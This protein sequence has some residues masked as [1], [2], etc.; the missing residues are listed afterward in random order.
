M[1]IQTQSSTCIKAVKTSVSIRVEGAGKV[2]L[3][4]QPSIKSNKPD[5]VLHLFEQS[6]PLSFSERFPKLTCF[7]IS[8]AIV[9]TALV[10]EIDCLRGAGYFWR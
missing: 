1:Q 3:R 9:A 4:P 2:P 6:Q 7:L 5:R 8:C 10:T